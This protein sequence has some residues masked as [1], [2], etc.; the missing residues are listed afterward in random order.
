M[1]SWI[2]SVSL[3]KWDIILI[4]QIEKT[5]TLQKIS[6][7]WAFT[8]S[9]CE[10]DPVLSPAAD[11]PRAGTSHSCHHCLLQLLNTFFTRIPH[12]FTSEKYQQLP[13]SST[14]QWLVLCRTHPKHALKMQIANTFP[15]VLFIFDLA[16]VLCGTV[17]FTNFHLHHQMFQQTKFQMYLTV[18]L[19]QTL[20]PPQP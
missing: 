20:I 11:S 9:G 8:C 10:V 2:L 16:K 14:I 4:F 6:K 1:N 19:K 12:Q 15:T 17:A 13:V 7:F 3:R 5:E 18:K